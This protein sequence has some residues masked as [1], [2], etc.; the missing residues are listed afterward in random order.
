LTEILQALSDNPSAFDYLKARGKKILENC[1]KEK[2]V[3]TVEAIIAGYA[4]KMKTWKMPVI[5]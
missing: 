2:A 3:E 1:S 5:P 4:K